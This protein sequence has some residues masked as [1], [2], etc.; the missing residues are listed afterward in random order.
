[1][2]TDKKFG[3]T[4]G[5]VLIVLI[6][7]GIIATLTLPSLLREVQ[8]KSRI[9]AL[10]STIDSVQ[11][12]LEKELIEN[13]TNNLNNTD[14]IGNRDTFF[15]EN[16][17]LVDPAPAQIFANNYRFINGDAPQADDLVP[18][19]NS[20]LLKNGVAIGVNEDGTTMAI[21]V[22]G[23]NRP[24]IVGVDYFTV[25]IA[26]ID[27]R[28]R[29]VRAGDVGQFLVNNDNNTCNEMRVSCT[30]TRNASSCYSALVLSGFNPRYTEN[31]GCNQGN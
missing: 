29:G 7:I 24:N 15:E 8:A 3:F 31:D 6:I 10:T 9:N 27:D 19:A 30:T 14:F 4:L 5:E 11:K 13:R 16:L 23:A 18:I 21:D 26:L 12:A 17:T 1:M 25:A 20:Y 2:K 22:N 28:N